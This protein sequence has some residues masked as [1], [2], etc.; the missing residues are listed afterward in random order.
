MSPEFKGLLELFRK[1]GLAYA[2]N[3]L[4]MIDTD[5]LPYPKATTKELY[6]NMVDACI[7]EYKLQLQEK[8]SGKSKKK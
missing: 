6:Y 7:E 2:N 4:K 3:M 8:Q 1:E 5:E